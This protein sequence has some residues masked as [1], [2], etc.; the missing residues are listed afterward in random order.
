MK[1]D[2]DRISSA[3]FGGFAAEDYWQKAKDW[4]GSTVLPVVNLIDRGHE[5]AKRNIPGY[6]FFTQWFNDDPV[7]AT[8]GAL[9]GVVVLV[10][11]GKAIAAMSGGVAGLL[12]GGL[13]G[14]LFKKL[15]VGATLG[16]VLHQTLRFVVRGA[17]FLWN[18]NWNVKDSEIVAQ[19]QAIIQNIYSQFGEVLGSTVGTLLCGAAPVE[20]AKRLPI[21]K[22]RPG[23]LAQIKEIS[24]VGPDGNL[25]HWLDEPPELYDE[26]IESFKGLLITLKNQGGRYIFLESF[27]NTRKWVR[28]AAQ[29]SQWFQDTFPW[30][31]NRLAQ[32]GSEESSPWSFSNAVEEWI[33][34]IPDPN[35][36]AF[37]EEFYENF[38]DTCSES[39][40][41]VADG[42]R[43]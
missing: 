13:G 41:I 5:W 20:I 2:A 29:N 19:Q 33:D 39:V 16:I 7:G 32:W 38:L 40:M 22:M 42:F 8:A 28:A 17:T 25:T 21:L 31:A 27:K 35:I 18:F 36:Q 10:V 6:G 37:T 43:G 12:K 4:I 34:N 9:L 30:L 11:G 14:G 3:I 15:F 23:L 26:L 1:I 24:E